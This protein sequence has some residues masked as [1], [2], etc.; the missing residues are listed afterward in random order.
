MPL[1]DKVSVNRI[2][3]PI[4]VPLC[5]SP[6]VTCPVALGWPLW[7]TAPDWCRAG[8]RA[9]GCSETQVA[10]LVAGAVAFPQCAWNARPWGECPDP[11]SLLSV[12]SS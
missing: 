12:K 8:A 10:E 11:S 2:L 3:C 4:P 7:G 1:L 6:A 5:M 9:A